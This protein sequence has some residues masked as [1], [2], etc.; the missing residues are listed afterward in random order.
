MDVIKAWI[1]DHFPGHEN[2]FIGGVIGLIVAILFFNLGFWRTLFLV[3]LVLTG[4]AVGQI[5]DGSATLIAK[6]RE[7]FSDRR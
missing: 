4:I 7:F 3:I 2:A 6:I 5:F 1:H